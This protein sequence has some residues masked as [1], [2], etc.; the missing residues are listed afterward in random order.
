[1]SGP[2]SA[3]GSGEGLREAAGRGGLHLALLQTEEGV[4]PNLLEAGPHLDVLHALFAWLLGRKDHPFGEARRRPWAQ[5]L[6]SLQ[7]EDGGFGL[8]RGGP[9]H[10]DVTCE[11][12][13]ALRLA[14]VE[15]EHPALR[16]AAAWLAGREGGRGCGAF[17]LLKY[18]WAGAADGRRAAVPAPEHYYFLDYRRWPALVRQQEAC[19]AALA[20]TAYLR[21]TAPWNGSGLPPG[22]GALPLSEAAAAD[23]RPG[24]LTAALIEKWARLAPRALR[25]PI[26]F[27][28]YDAMVEE[29]LRWPSLP[30]ALHA[31]LAVQAAGG[32]GSAALGRFERVIS[33]LGPEDAG[34]PPRPC[35]FANRST[36]LA[37]LAL[38]GGEAVLRAS[39]ALKMRFRRGG[40]AEGREGP[41][42]GWPLGDLH[43]GP[44]AETTALVLLALERTGQLDDG[45]AR[46]ACDALIAA[47]QSDGGWRAADGEP[48]AP[49]VTGLVLEALAACGQPQ[50]QP[51]VRRAVKF[52]EDSQHAEAWWRGARGICRLY[53][54][55][56]A[57]R[58]LRAAGCDD[59]EAAVLRA[60]EWLRSIQNADGGWGEHPESF[61]S[62]EFREAASTPEHTAWALI[63]LLAGGDT[64]S[65][66]VR[67]GFAWLA[68]HQREDGSWEAAAP[69]L[70]GVACAPYLHDPLG[71]CA[72]P[73]I[74][75]REGENISA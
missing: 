9:S 50:D 18:A 38:G 42:A 40:S 57:L 19:R 29:A 4:W 62:G 25:D 52:L 12:W 33:M 54:T 53:G 16:R 23:L 27:R 74:A 71:A 55:A 64:G 15:G 36:A 47:Q 68:E 30:V 66:S 21:G 41:G 60:G 45:L 39:A 1:M 24:G 51:P 32:R 7:N 31:A 44:D 8:W 13:L 6:L 56:M 11:A 72:W 22:E 61:E 28:A 35:D 70:P 63:G 73:L 65:E 34:A 2:Q 46:Q 37:M 20:V 43:A 26:A 17:T 3:D 58:G 59:R 10:A 5:R 75:L 14:G 67:R 48:P 69:T 49:D